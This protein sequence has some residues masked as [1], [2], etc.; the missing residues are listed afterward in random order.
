MNIV[1]YSFLVS[2]FAGLSTLIGCIFLFFKRGNQKVLISS[3]AFAAGVMCCVSFTDLLPS[4]LTMLKTYY[5]EFPSFL[6]CAIAFSVGVIFSMLIDKYLPDQSGRI[7]EN[8]GKLYR[9]GIIS[10]LAIILHNIP[11]GIA[12]F[13]TTTANVSL[14]ITLAVAI[15]LHN[16]PEGI[17]I[18]VPIYYATGSKMKAFFYTL[19]SGLSEPLGALLAYLFLSPYVTDFMMGLLLCFIAGIMTHI[20]FYELLP[21]SL[22]YQDKKRTGISF[23]VGVFVMILSHILLS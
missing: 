23:L 19:I 13:M 2:G 17:S 1:Y 22:A 20:S 5:L 9:I 16:I 7:V 3:L 11:E 8:Q 12:T 4:S 21:T 18:S 14:G 15:A 10:M 6:F